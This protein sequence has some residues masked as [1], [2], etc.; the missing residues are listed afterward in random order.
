MQDNT[1][2]GVSA[3]LVVSG[4]VLGDVFGGSSSSRSLLCGALPSLM[5]EPFRLEK[6][7]ALAEASASRIV[8]FVERLAEY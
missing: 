1:V 4:K 5:P 2:G 7:L 3:P 6:E 8:E